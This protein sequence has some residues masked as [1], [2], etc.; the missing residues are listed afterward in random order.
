MS[1]HLPVGLL[2]LAI[3]IF[4]ASQIGATT[5]AKVTMNWQLD[6]LEKQSAQ[7]KE[8]KAK[9]AD[10]VVK[11]DDIVKKV[12]SL[13][14]QYTALLTDVLDLAATD[15]DAAKVVEKYKIQRNAAAEGAAAD[16]K[17][18]E[19]PKPEEPKPEIK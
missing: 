16:A 15:P 4:M 1:V 8:A 14:Q 7:L 5:R 17:K 19:E 11:R 2:C 18:S 9:F 10:A 3:A 13:Q 6:N 12:D